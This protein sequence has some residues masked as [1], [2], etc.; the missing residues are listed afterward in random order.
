MKKCCNPWPKFALVLTLY[1][2]FLVWVSS[3]WGILAVPF[4]FDIYITKRINWTWWKRSKNPIIRTV[5]GWIDAILFALIAVYF[6]NLFFFQNYQIP[7]SSLEKSLLVG[8]FLFVSKLSYGPRVPNTPLTMPLTQHTMPWGGKSYLESPHWKYRRVKGLGHV[9]RNDIVVFNY[10]AGDTLASA[11]AYQAQDFYM[12]CYEL[13]TRLVKGSNTINYDSLSITQQ[14]TLFQRYYTQGRN[15]IASNPT[16]Y[17]EITTRPV[18][19]REN[20]VKRCVA[21]PGDTLQIIDR[22]IY[23][24]GKAQKAPENVQFNYNLYP[25]KKQISSSY[26]SSLGISKEDQHNPI[27]LTQAMVKELSA[28]KDL[29]QKLVLDKSTADAVEM[30]PHNLV[31][32][33]DRDNFGPLWMPKRGATLQLTLE[34]LPLYERPIRVYEE[35]K[36]EVKAGKIYINGKE[37][38]SYTFKMDYYWMM[39]DNR[40]NSLDSRY[41]GFVPEDHIVGKPILVWLSLDKD[42]GWFNGKIRWSRLFKLVDNIK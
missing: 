16:N 21:L 25:T 22:T 1:V 8:D 40:H 29:V 12:L 15:Y 10:P 36:L 5:M 17:G 3:W 33:W 20:Y 35:N 7:S 26:L 24:D 18:D 39:G 41:W 13:G 14:R 11:P 4:I 32:H 19:R 31:T 34:N 30:Y 27:P 37:A 9:K 23:I 6:V 2:L 42:K 38:K 28:R